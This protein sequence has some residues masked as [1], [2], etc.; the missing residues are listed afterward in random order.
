M[1]H[2]PHPGGLLIGGGGGGGSTELG[3]VKVKVKGVKPETGQLVY[4]L[5]AMASHCIITGI[6]GA[7]KVGRTPLS[8]KKS[9]A[10]EW[11]YSG[12]VKSNGRWR[13]RETV[14]LALGL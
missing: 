12:N 5:L 10:L 3:L 7:S 11:R 6:D 13:G 1:P 2:R 4:L 14:C 8:H 9:G